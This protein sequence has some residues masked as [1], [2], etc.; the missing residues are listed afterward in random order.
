MGDKKGKGTSLLHR[1][2]KFHFVHTLGGG[3]IGQM[4]K[5]LGVEEY[6]KG[7]QKKGR[8]KTLITNA[9]RD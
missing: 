3:G 2:K 4:G 1:E 6:D 7:I 9:R 8:E 5:S